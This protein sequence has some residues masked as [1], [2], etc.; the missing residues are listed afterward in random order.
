MLLKNISLIFAVL[1]LSSALANESV[2]VAYI[3]DGD[4]IIVVRNGLNNTVRLIG[5]DTPESKKNARAFK[6]AERSGSDISYIISQGKRATAYVRG[7][8]KRGDIVSLELDA[9]ERDIYGRLLAYVY[10]SDGRMLNEI[11][12]KSGYAS[13]LTIPP[14]VKYKSRFLDAYTYAREKKLGLWA[15]K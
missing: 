2:R 6:N 8:I 14:N 9:Q 1:T 10:L 4:T 7:I 5:M 11:I 12:V 3:V 15:D 13:V